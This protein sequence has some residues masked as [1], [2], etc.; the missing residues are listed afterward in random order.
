MPELIDMKLPKK[1][2][3]ELKK[4]TCCAPLSSGDQ[5]RWPYGLQ[6]RFEKE[7][8]DKIPSLADLKVGDRVI[9]QGEACVTSIRISERKNNNQDHSVE[10]QIEKISV[11]PAKKVPLEKMKMSDY[12]KERE[13]K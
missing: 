3:E 9:V 1:T 7:Q 11:E 8:V 13:K 12:R 2:K 4:D 10:L 6:I 5:D